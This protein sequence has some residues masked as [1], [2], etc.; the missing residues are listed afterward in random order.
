MRSVL[1]FAGCVVLL[2]A[3]SLLRGQEPTKTEAT[4][5]EPAKIKIALYDD[6]GAT[7]SK[8]K[9]VIAANKSDRFVIERLKAEDIRAGKL[10]G[11][12]VVVQPG[13]SSSQQGAALAEEGREKVRQFVKDGGGYVG[14]CAGAY[15]ATNDYDWSLHIL[16]AKVLDRKHWARGIADLELSFPAAGKEML[17]VSTDRVI[18]H[19]HQGPLLAPAEK[20]GLPAY[21]ELA[22]FETEVAKNG[23]PTGVMIGTTAIA[24]AEFGKGRVL[25]FSPHPELT[26]DQEKML[27]RGLEWAAALDAK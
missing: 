22:K 13:G 25:C 15:L 6:K 26:K 21:R 4:K 7:S 24:A 9:F 1:R 12:Q 16:N 18:L 17:G 23:A 27:H 19:Y 20:E 11:F 10:K 2:A 8:E 14:I 3:C 5:I